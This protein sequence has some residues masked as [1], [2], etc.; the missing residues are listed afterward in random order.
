MYAA[1]FNMYYYIWDYFVL[2][3]FDPMASYVPNVAKIVS[4]LKKWLQY[5]RTIL[6]KFITSL[7]SIDNKRPMILK[8]AACHLRTWTFIP[9]FSFPSTSLCP[10]VLSSHD[11]LFR[12]ISPKIKSKHWYLVRTILPLVLII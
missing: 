1:R 7:V 12:K 2:R 11:N 9:I 6:I 8:S 10:S 4:L 5:G 3:M